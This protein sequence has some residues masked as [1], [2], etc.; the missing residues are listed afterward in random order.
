MTVYDINPNQIRISLTHTEVI[1][2]FGSYSKLAKMSDNIKASLSALVYNVAKAH[3]KTQQNYKIKGRIYAKENNGCKI[4]IY[5]TVLH[6]QKSIPIIYSFK[7]SENLICAVN[8]LYKSENSLRSDL[9]KMSDSYRLIIEHYEN[10]L[11]L[12]EFDCKVFNSP[13]MLAHTKEYGKPLILNN[14]IYRLGKAFIKE[15]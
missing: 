15:P 1:A 5:F 10:S 4:N 7:N 12:N 2:C 6:K 3:I 14:A 13:I 8:M 11:T 9:Y